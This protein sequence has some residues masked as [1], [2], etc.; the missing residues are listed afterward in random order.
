MPP[1]IESIFSKTES[2][3]QITIPGYENEMLKSDPV[4]PTMFVTTE[5]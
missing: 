5:D 2:E 3:I 4:F 1:Y